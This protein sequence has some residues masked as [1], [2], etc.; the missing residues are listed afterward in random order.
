MSTCPDTDLY[1]A[2]V[3]GEIPSPWKEKLEEHLSTCEKCRL[4]EQ[5]YRHLHETVLK[6]EKEDSDVSTEFLEKSFRK[7]SSRW[8]IASSNV[9]TGNPNHKWAVGKKTVTM[10]YFALAAMF[11]AAVF[12][13]SFFT[14]KNAES[15]IS[16]IQQGNK[17][18][19][20]A[21]KAEMLLAGL[22]K[23]QNNI[24]PNSVSVYS[25]DF[26]TIDE[27]STYV[28]SHENNPGSLSKK[29]YSNSS[30]TKFALIDSLKMFSQN[31]NLF[32][33]GKSKY[34][35]IKLPEVIHFGTES[36]RQYSGNREYI[37]NV[38]RQ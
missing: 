26:S 30:S 24:S 21:A 10:P 23:Y 27:I 17:M 9:L 1:S 16:D 37:T 11:L 20:E 31:K 14:V 4:I 38:S 8:E 25:N 35:I 28:T 18:A 33:N 19:V 7:V 2:Y 22:S 6:T 3:D 34:I 15:R 29:N 13:P 32:P 5:K 36:N 12:I